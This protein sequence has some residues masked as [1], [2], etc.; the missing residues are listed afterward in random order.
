VKSLAVLWLRR[1]G[2]TAGIVA[3]VAGGWAGYLRLSGNF[4]PIEAGVIYRSG[5]LS[6]PQFAE[7]I[8]ENGIRTI[9]N[10]RGDNTGQPWYDAEMEASK[11][12]RVRHVDFPL[13]AG[14]ELTDEQVTQLTTLLRDSPRPVLIHCEAGADRSGVASALY[15]LLVAKRPAQE[16][17]EQLS[18]RYGHFPWLTSRTAAMDRTFD[19]VA[20]RP[21]LTQAAD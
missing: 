7:R 16:A 21:I 12:A 5:Q 8:E 19:R 1:F 15:K 11:A 3:G 2:L 20:S 13:S 9:I 10:L 17:S 18:F 6:G 14:R 4:H